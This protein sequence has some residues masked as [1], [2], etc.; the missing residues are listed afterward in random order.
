MQDLAWNGTKEGVEAKARD[1]LMEAG[2]PMEQVEKI[3]GG[4]RKNYSGVD[5]MFKQP[6]NIATSKTRIR[7]LQKM[8]SHRVCRCA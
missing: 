8:S 7:M 6:A 4:N 5:I 2:V 1:I 3:D